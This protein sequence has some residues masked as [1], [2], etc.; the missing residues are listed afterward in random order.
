MDSSQRKR[1]SYS[2]SRGFG[3]S[4]L[5]IWF[6]ARQYK[7]KISKW[8]LCKNIKRNE[9]LSIARRRIA[10]KLAGDNESSSLIDDSKVGADKI[11]RYLRRNKIDESTL[12]AQES[13][14]TGKLYR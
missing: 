4:F 3:L 12:L 6:R 13:I 2:D 14:S 10:R 5:I 7:R 11:D 8:G 9:M 1:T